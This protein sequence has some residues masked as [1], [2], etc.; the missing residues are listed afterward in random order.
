MSGPADLDALSPSAVRAV[1]LARVATSFRLAR[2]RGLDHDPRLTSSGGT[3]QVV[4]DLALI[5][6]EVGPPD[7]LIGVLLAHPDAKGEARVLLSHFNLTARDVL[8]ADYPKVDF[9]DLGRHASSLPDSISPQGLV[10][11]G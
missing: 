10:E 6:R 9:A 2:R 7:L 8:P 5:D 11:I 1:H 4:A 3:D